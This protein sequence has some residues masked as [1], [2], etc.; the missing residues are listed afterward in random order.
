MCTTCF[1]TENYF[2]ERLY[3]RISYYS[4][5]KRLHRQ[6]QPMTFVMETWCVLF[7]ETQLLNVI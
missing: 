4:Q 7:E 5:N 2:S 3:F 1:D 6:N